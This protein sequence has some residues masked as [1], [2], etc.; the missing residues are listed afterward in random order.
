MSSAPV[1]SPT[2]RPHRMKKD[3]SF[4]GKL[5]GTLARKKKAKE[6]LFWPHKDLRLD[7]E[8]TANMPSRSELVLNR[9]LS[10]PSVG[11]RTFPMEMSMADAQRF[12]SGP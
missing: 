5:G 10:D 4:L 1:R 11:S 7:N 8:I 6:A 12:L 2:L 3:E 9:V